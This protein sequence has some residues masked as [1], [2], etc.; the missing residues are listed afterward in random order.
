LRVGYTFSSNPIN[1]DVAFFNVPAT[2]II[3]HAFQLGLT[4]E[5]NERL[6]IDAAYHHGMSGGKTEGPMLNPQ[7]IE[8]GGGPYGVVPGSNVAYEMTTDLFTLG[9]SFRL[10]K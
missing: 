2:A 4:Y 6:G 3:K 10:N 5:V 9:V 1:E 7:M 8:Q